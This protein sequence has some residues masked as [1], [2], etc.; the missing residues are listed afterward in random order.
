MTNDLQ[1]TLARLD[2]AMSRYYVTWPLSRDDL[3]LLRRCAA[4]WCKVQEQK[5]EVFCEP[6][7]MSTDA[8]WEA[9]A[10]HISEHG[11]RATGP[12]PLEAVEAVEERK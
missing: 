7:L 8:I 2:D 5:L 10:H 9:V 12:T 11:P 4:A 6:I 1:S 3:G